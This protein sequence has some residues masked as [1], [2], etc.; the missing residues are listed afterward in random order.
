MHGH[1]L[2]RHFPQH[3]GTLQS[4]P[5]NYLS[6]MSDDTARKQVSDLRVIRHRVR[7]SVAIFRP[8][9]GLQV[10]IPLVS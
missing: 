9:N 7:H 10:Q 5:I 2:S 4:L 8:D 6:I 1:D 3:H